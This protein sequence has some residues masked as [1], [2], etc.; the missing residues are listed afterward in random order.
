MEC[1]VIIFITISTHTTTSTSTNTIVIYNFN[2][3]NNTK[4]SILSATTDQAIAVLLCNVMPRSH[5]KKSS[6]QPCCN[7]ILCN[8]YASDSNWGP[9]KCAWW[10][11]CEQYCYLAASVCVRLRC[12]AP[13]WDCSATQNRDWVQ[14]VR[15]P[16]ANW[17]ASDCVELRPTPIKRSTVCHCRCNV[18]RPW[19][20][21][22][23]LYCERSVLYCVVLQTVC[24]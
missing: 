1:E 16:G 2:S 9:H 3:D 8:S 5:L 14:T 17:F 19:C 18:C 11:C 20:E 21:C 15:R 13:Y 22:S 10:M 23:A 24:I 7:P 4:V 6:L 12:T